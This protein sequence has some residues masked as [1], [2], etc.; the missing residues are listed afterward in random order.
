M[1][2]SKSIAMNFKYLLSIL[3]FS[4]SLHAS[5]CWKIKNKDTKALCE[6]KF[7][8]K[9]NCWLIKSKDTQAYCEA[10]AYGQKS[11]W[12]I[13]EKDLQAMCEAE[14]GR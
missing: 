9:K 13:K 12:K 11:C 4:F 7:E 14:V 6:S 2:K 5:S 1:I 8:H 10:T 3:L